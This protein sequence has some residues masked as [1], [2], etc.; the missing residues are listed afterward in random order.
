MTLVPKIELFFQFLSAERRLRVK[1]D[2]DP[3]TARVTKLHAEVDG[4]HE[5]F[6][7]RN[8]QGFDI[9][10]YEDPK[11]RGQFKLSVKQE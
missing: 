4:H 2:K 11:N 6:D 8:S 1:L 10:I 7:L 9:E 5:E 3:Q